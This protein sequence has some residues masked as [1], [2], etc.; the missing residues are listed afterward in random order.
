MALRYEIADMAPGPMREAAI[1]AYAAQ[2]RAG[3]PPDRRTRSARTR[4][5]AEVVAALRAEKRMLRGERLSASERERAVAAV[6]D[7]LEG[8]GAAREVAKA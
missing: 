2:A 7:A 5:A 4:P 8:C 6:D 3:G 1:E